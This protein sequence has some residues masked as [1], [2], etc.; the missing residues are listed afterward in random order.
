MQRFALSEKGERVSAEEAV[1]QVNYVCPECL[2]LVRLK[3]GEIKVAHFFHLEE[4]RACRW[5]TRCQVHTSIQENIAQRL[6]NCTVECFFPEI[7]RIADIAYHPSK[8]VFEIQVSPI[9]AQEVRARTE[10][11]LRIGWHVIW[12]LH[13]E[14]FG[15]KKACEAEKALQGIPHYFTSFFDKE[16]LCVW[17]ESSFVYKKKRMWFKPFS[18]ITI[19]NFVPCTFFTPIPHVNERE[20]YFKNTQEWYEFRKR[21]WS[22]CLS[23]DFLSK[24][25]VNGVCQL[26]F[27]SKHDDNSSLLF[28]RLRTFLFLVWLRL[29]GAR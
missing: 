14:Q 29:V 21:E 11:Y 13:A 28:L 7:S 17:D 18:R 1:S 27:S 6:G 9:S 22:C 8:V 4:G 20:S 16:K 19:S 12:L 5:K 25:P 23:H 2:S 10:D 26:S 15:R 24:G 3:R